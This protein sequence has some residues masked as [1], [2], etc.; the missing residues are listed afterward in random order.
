MHRACH[1]HLLI[2]SIGKN[3]NRIRWKHLQDH[4]PGISVSSRDE[5]SG[6]DDDS[7]ELFKVAKFSGINE[8]N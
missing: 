2:T 5:L 4:G 3:R 1:P 7:F 6:P 8:P